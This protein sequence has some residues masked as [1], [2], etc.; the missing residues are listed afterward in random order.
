MTVE[1]TDICMGYVWVSTSFSIV[2]SKCILQDN[3]H[4]LNFTYQ[5]YTGFTLQPL[6]P[7]KKC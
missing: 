2:S 6:L 3:N 1:M 4:P 5:I 7:S